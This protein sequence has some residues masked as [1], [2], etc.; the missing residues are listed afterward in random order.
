MSINLVEVTTYERMPAMVNPDNPA[1][2]GYFRRPTPKHLEVFAIID[3][4]SRSWREKFKVSSKKVSEEQI[5]EV[6][7][8]F[9]DTRRDKTL[10]K[11]RTFVSLYHECEEVARYEDDQGMSGWLDPQGVFHPC[12]FGEHVKFALDIL[13]KDEEH[14]RGSDEV[15]ELV[16]NQYIPMSVMHLSTNG[17]ISILGEL[18]PEQ[19]TWFDMFFFK[20][21][22]SQRSTLTREAKKQGIK[23]KY[24]W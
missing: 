24:D 14:Y 1:F 8:F 9:N 19:I 10:E 11:E 13:N 7:Q 5:K 21:A 6:I 17:F 2:S 20:L 23:L 3:N 4:G 16:S 22:P 15:G 12:G 18:T